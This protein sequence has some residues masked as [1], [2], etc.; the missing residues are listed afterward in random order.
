MGRS[1]LVVLCFGIH[2]PGGDGVLSAV[3]CRRLS[4]VYSV[5]SVLRSVGLV[6]V[7]FGS[8]ATVRV[9][10]FE[11]IAPLWA[12][13]TGSFSWRRSRLSRLRGGMPR[14]WLRPN[15]FE[16]GWR[17][18]RRLA[19]RRVREALGAEPGPAWSGCFLRFF[20]I[21]TPLGKLRGIFLKLRIAF[22]A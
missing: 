16:G 3:F 5:R 7:L 1:E 21:W 10:G 8:P 19:A 13:W 2:R 14:I 9:G 11:E 22:W 12:A 17:C 18:G 20:S 6:S 4:L 15:P